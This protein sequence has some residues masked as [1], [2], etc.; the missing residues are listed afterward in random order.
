VI[1]FNICTIHGSY[2]NQTDRMR[3]MVRIGYRHPDNA[4]IAGQSVGRPGLIVAGCRK[5]R[6]GQEPFD[7]EVG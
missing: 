3:R 5:R 2:I 6:S 1:C 7:T 4:Q